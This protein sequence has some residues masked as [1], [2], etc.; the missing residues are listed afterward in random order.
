MKKDNL[1]EI[2]EKY[3]KKSKGVNATIVNITPLKLYNYDIEK[4]LE[5]EFVNIVMVLVLN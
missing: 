3:I 5:T 1:K 2:F 4:K